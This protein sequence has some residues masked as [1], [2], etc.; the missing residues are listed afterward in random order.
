MDTTLINSS[1]VI[2]E[3][4]YDPNEFN[5][6]E[7]LDTVQGE[8]SEFGFI[9]GPFGSS[10]GIKISL[11]KPGYFS[12][13]DR[14]IIIEQNG[15]TSF[16]SWY[17]TPG[18]DNIPNIHYP[19]DGDTL[20]LFCTKQF[21]SSDLYEFV[22]IGAKLDS[23]K[24]DSHNSKI[25]VV[26]NPYVAGATW[27]DHDY[28]LNDAGS[29]YSKKAESQQVFLDF[30]GVSAESPRRK[31][32]GIYHAQTYGKPGQRIQVILLDTRYFRSPLNNVGRPKVRTEG[33]TGPYGITKDPDATILGEEQWQWLE[34]QLLQPA[35]LRIVASSIQVVS[36][37]HGWECWGTMPSERKRL[38]DLLNKTTA[39]GVV[40]LSGDRHHAEISRI[41]G[42]LPYPL[43]DI[44]ASGLNQ[45]KGFSNEHN[46][47]RI[48]TWY[49]EEHFG[50]ILI[51]WETD[52]PEITFQI[53]DIKGRPVIQH[54]T[55]LSAISP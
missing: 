16:V 50:M 43:Y 40:V 32:A 8:W 46:P 2:P 3:Y 1:E 28:G 36:D 35:E 52:N 13:A 22:S 41:E 33:R 44:T 38:Y 26:P 31:R 54:R 14:I 12:Y 55:L 42:K 19:K 47:H 21:S 4:I 15:D 20:K 5:H 18:H 45:R 23:E 25:K 17:I 27:D 7:V 53:R 39:N 34:D 6:L 24:I 30:F 49:R 10:S 48:G 29:E 9:P 51:D 37:Q 11:S